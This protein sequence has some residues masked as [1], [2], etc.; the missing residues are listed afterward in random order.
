MAGLL[1]RV[2]DRNGADSAKEDAARGRLV[3][4]LRAVIEARDAENALLRAELEAQLERERRKDRKRG[5]QPGHPGAGQARDPAPDERT[6]A[7]PP[8]ECS[9]CGAGLE[10]AERAG[11][12]WSQV[13]DVKITRFVTEYL[14]PLL[15]CPCCGK[16]NAGRGRRS[17]VPGQRVL[18]ARDQH[19]GGAAVLLRECAV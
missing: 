15:A 8:A 14:L 18:R 1:P 7:P 13:W 12:W 19:R 2:Y 17:G 10:G 9:R 4:R 11:T 16:V 6:E 3:V 5:G